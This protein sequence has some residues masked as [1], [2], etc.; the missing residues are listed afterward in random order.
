MSSEFPRLLRR[1]A[2]VPI[3]M[4]HSL[5]ETGSVISTSPSTFAGQMAFLRDEGVKTLSLPELATCIREGTAPPKAVAITFD[6]GF[7]SVYE[8][9]F[10]IL[11]RLRLR[12]TVFLVTAY[13]GRTNDWPGQSA[14]VPR[15]RLLQ[16]SQIEA[17]A[18]GG[19]EFGAHT[20]THPNLAS[21]P[22]RAA[23]EEILSSR[24]VIE[25]RLQRP[26]HAFAYPYGSVRGPVRDT[27]RAAFQVACAT[28]LDVVRAGSDVHELERIDAYYLRKAP[29]FRRLFRPEMDLYLLGR[30]VLRELRSASFGRV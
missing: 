27:V 25:D 19:V 16:W 10:P 3:L 20:M 7:E 15:S 5:D 18:A 2:G 9:A 11:Q 1:P 29:I 23:I 4:Y 8:H 28:R 30:R 6:D 17:M 14:A 21:I 26:V 12:A 22:H 24:R 13:C